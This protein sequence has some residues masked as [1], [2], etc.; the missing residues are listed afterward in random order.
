MVSQSLLNCSA[1]SRALSAFLSMFSSSLCL[2]LAWIKSPLLNHHFSCDRFYLIL[3]FPGIISLPSSKLSFCT[4]FSLLAL[5]SLV[6]PVIKNSYLV[7]WAIGI[8]IDH[9]D[10]MYVWIYQYR[11]FVSFLSLKAALCQYHVVTKTIPLKKVTYSNLTQME[12][13]KSNK[14]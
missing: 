10:H 4:S 13:I 12:L 8:C 6:T 9:M 7:P 3:C 2:I 1:C 14:L 5:N 11:A